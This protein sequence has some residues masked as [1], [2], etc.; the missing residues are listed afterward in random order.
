MIYKA[1]AV[2]NATYI[3]ANVPP[4]NTVPKEVSRSNDVS[5]LSEDIKN[6]K[7]W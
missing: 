7:N 5:T 2:Q 1:A 6:P 3:E 4:R